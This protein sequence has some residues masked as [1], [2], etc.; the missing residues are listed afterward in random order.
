MIR[1]K[2]VSGSRRGAT[3]SYGREPVRVGR[4]ASAELRFA[5][6]QDAIVSTHHAQIVFERGAYFLVDTGS[7]N[8]TLI[9]GRRDHQAGT[10]VRR[11]GPLRLPRWS[12]G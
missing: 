6:A 5:D 11:Q 7:T 1:L 2:I 8:G 9:N 4:G 10:Q 12:R 3:V